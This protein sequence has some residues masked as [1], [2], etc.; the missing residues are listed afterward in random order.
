MTSALT[1]SLEIKVEPELALQALGFPRRGRSTHHFE[2]EN[3]SLREP[4]AG[5]GAGV[6][7]QYDR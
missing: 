5:R 1:R 3:E 6:L 7:E 4:F 2:T